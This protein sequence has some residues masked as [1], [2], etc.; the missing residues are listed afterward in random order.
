MVQRMS[1]LTIQ[2]PDDV[3]ERLAAA[4]RRS[5]KSPARFVRETLEER[6]TNGNTSRDASLFERSQDLCGSVRGGPRDLAA[7]KR[8]LKAYGSWKG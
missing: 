1:T 5:G 8:H 4:A 2:L 6:L 7:N 3:K